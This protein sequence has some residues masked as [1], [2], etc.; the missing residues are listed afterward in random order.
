MKLP[1][2][3]YHY[4][5]QEGLLGILQ[6]NKLWMTNIL[7]LNDSSE[8]KHTLDFVKVELKN[9]LDKISGTGI[10]R[11]SILNENCIDERK[12]LIYN[13][14]L[15]HYNSTY[16]G[17]ISDIYVFSLSQE[18][19]DLSQWRGYCPKGVGFCIEFDNKKMSSIMIKKTY[20][21]LTKC[22]YDKEQK[23][24]LVKSLF[25]SIEPWFETNEK[26]K[27]YFNAFRTQFNKPTIS[28][29]EIIELVHHLNIIDISSNIKNESF[30]NE[31]E[32]RIVQNIKSGEM[33]YRRGNSMIIPYIEGNLLDENNKLPISKIIVGPTPHPELSV[34]SVDSLLK[35]KGYQGVEVIKSEIPYRSW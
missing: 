15:S 20:Y 6:T 2:Y 9:R 10:S 4:T 18:K 33:K 7:Y 14:L 11:F 26:S 28:D 12:Y 30:M 29:Q 21:K 1:Q 24:K 35:S 22:I 5:S 13:D 23:G 34:I 25:D 31:N 16:S 27:S 8:F 3:L 19:D 32:Y 17:Q